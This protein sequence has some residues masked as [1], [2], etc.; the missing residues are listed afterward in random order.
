M[1]RAEKASTRRTI[2][3]VTRIFGVVAVVVLVVGLALAFWAGYFD[4]V[5]IDY[6][7]AGPYHVLYREHAGPYEGLRFVMRDVFLYYRETF[8]AT[9]KIG[10]GV[11]RGGPQSAHGDSL[12]CQAGCLTDTLI[13][14]PSEPYLSRTIPKREALVA[15][16][17]LRSP[18][19]YM[20]GVVKSYPALE[21]YMAEEGLVQ[22]GDVVELYDLGERE[23]RYVA[24]VREE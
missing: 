20:T 12:L 10:F 5:R 18:F 2:R 22:D 23:L 1:A 11:Y 3:L 21:E 4:A 13:D 16:F 19:S 8:E 17:P 9:P 15:T 14:S 7:E 6:R 24:P